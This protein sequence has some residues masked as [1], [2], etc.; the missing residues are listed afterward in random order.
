MKKYVLCPFQLMD[1]DELR[2]ALKK[3]RKTVASARYVL[4]CYEMKLENAVQE[5]NYIKSRT[6]GFLSDLVAELTEPN[7]F[8]D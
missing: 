2:E 1:V 7:A 8:L 4:Y 3:A 6:R 5:I